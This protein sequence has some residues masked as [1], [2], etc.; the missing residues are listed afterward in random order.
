MTDHP[1]LY[2]ASLPPHSQ[3]ASVFSQTNAPER[4]FEE[5]I[6]DPNAPFDFYSFKQHGYLTVAMESQAEVW[7]V[8]P[9][10]R[11]ARMILPCPTSQSDYYFIKPVSHVSRIKPAGDCRPLKE[12]RQ[13][14]IDAPA[15]AGYFDGTA[16]LH[17]SSQPS[18]LM[19]LDSFEIAFQSSDPTCSV[20]EMTTSRSS[21][22]NKYILFER[23]EQEP[24]LAI[25]RCRFRI[26]IPETLFPWNGDLAQFRIRVCALL[27]TYSP[28]GPGVP[29]LQRGPE[30]VH[31]FS[32]R[33]RTSR[34]GLP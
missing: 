24:N 4:I 23:P 21:R 29:M 16:E 15:H 6:M 3:P 7:D 11:Y 25:A 19:H 8:F 5:L 17:A 26:V 33:L 12:K 10:A 2:K 20:N 32:L 34:R 31:Q 18:A 1:E 28:E 30:Y 13:S 22:I 14:P 9:G 27:N